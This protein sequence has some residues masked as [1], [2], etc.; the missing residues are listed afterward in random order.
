MLLRIHAHT[1]RYRSTFQQSPISRLLH[2]NIIAQRE[3]PKREFATCFSSLFQRFLPVL[4]DQ[5]NNSLSSVDVEIADVERLASNS[6]NEWEEEYDMDDNGK[7]CMEEPTDKEFDS[8]VAFRRF[9]PYPQSRC[10]ETKY[11]VHVCRFPKSLHYTSYEQEASKVATAKHRY[12]F[13]REVR[14]VAFMHLEWLEG[15]ISRHEIWL[16]DVASYN[17]QLRKWRPAHHSH[18]PYVQFTVLQQANQL[19]EYRDHV[20]KQVDAYKEARINYRWLSDKTALDVKQIKGAIRASNS[21]TLVNNF[22]H[23]SIKPRCS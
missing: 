16:R 21:D 4:R 1:H 6:Q 20:L 9:D 11:S 14:N 8:K 13:L 3:N 10:S 12:G 19:L 2:P 15:I 22:R 7:Q 18:G 17:H 5:S 23:I